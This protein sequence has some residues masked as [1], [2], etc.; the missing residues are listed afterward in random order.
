MMK[1][2]RLLAGIGVLG[3]VF[4]GTFAGTFAGGIPLAHGQSAHIAAVVN[5]Q[6]I[7]DADVADRARLF[8]LSTGMPPTPDILVRLKPQITQQLID[9]TL[10]L[11]EINKRNIVVPEQDIVNAIAHIEQSNNMPAGALR[12]RLEAS[13]VDF[14]TLISQLRIEIGWQRVLH[15]VLGPGLRPTSGD[16]AAEKK[17]LKAELGSV[18]YHL[19][20]IFIPVE[21]PANEKN[22]RD[23][24]ATVIQQLRQ[25]A[26][27]P[28]V[29]AQFS[30]ADSAL[31]GGDLGFVS[32]NQLDPAVA[33]VV[34]TMPVGAISNPVRVPGGYD[35]VQL[36][37]TRSVGTDMQ[38]LLSMRQTYLPFPAPITN[39]QVGPQQAAVIGK[40]EA[41]SHNVHS[42][43]DME[44][45]NNQL[46]HIR[47]A[48]PG[49]INLANV[50]P[51]PFQALLANL[52]IGQ[53]SQP[54]VAPDGIS[55]VIVCSRKTA[56]VGLPS[57]DDIAA[58]IVNQRV[59]MESQQ[60]LDD[61][62]HRS[63][64]TQS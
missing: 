53:V 32:V 61:L 16:I 63:I 49:Q 22:A 14:Q 47:P 12:A 48:D 4:A 38:T 3:A 27:F 50:T 45:L 41:A 52:P 19:S 34:K 29:A 58:S 57:D 23:F 62:R 37:A 35:I 8:A 21:D 1:T 64:I 56:P 36:Q 30:Q 18:Q 46:G 40:L 11:Q 26:P 7:T 33:A 59:Q 10:E 5:G 13:G 2:Y 31:Q 54:L 60:L 20:E 25:G 39:G 6:L 43:A 55:I 24:A 44:A 9:E 15:Q 42:C 51:P 17:A 28:I